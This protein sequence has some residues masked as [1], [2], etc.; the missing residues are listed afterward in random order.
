MISLPIK[1]ENLRKNFGEQAIFSGEC[2]E[3]SDGITA[4]MGSSGKGKTTL[5]RILAGLDKD[6]TGNISGV[7]T[8]SY[9]PQRPSLFPW[10]SAE[11]NLTVICGESEE[12]ME[13]IRE[14][15]EAFGLFEARDKKPHEL[16]GGMCQRIAILRAWLFDSDTVILD[17]PF[18]G[19]D[20]ET[21]ASVITYLKKNKCASRRVIFTTH[22]EDEASA[23]ADSILR[24]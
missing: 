19:L 16:S 9:C 6:Y 17:E 18:K 12:A 15:L 24:I 4:V 2:F 7:K 1:I 22:S 5:F 23:F 11:K 20:S 21:K 8:I 10:F 13:K 14:G 3:F